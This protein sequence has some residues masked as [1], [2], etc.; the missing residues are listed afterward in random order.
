MAK[1][2]TVLITGTSSGIGRACAL[3]LAKNGYHVFA[4]VRRAE[5]G[6]SLLAESDGEIS[7]LVFDVTDDETRRKGVETIRQSVE[8]DGLDFLINN[9]GAMSAGP[10]EFLSIDNIREYLEINLIGAIALTQECLPLLRK[11]TGRIINLGSA[12]DLLTPPFFGGYTIAKWGMRGFHQALRLELRPSGIQCVLIVPGAIKT[13][14]WKDV[15][16]FRENLGLLSDGAGD[17]YGDLAI[18]MQNAAKSLSDSGLEPEV[19]AAAVERAMIA[20]RPRP[21]VIVGNDA[22]YLMRPLGALPTR[23]REQLMTRIF[24]LP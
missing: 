24:K 11:A 10:L 13:S 18:A 6:E 8:P 23:L 14:I 4:S 17:L 21:E 16:K 5:D 15:P 7:L 19:V 20:R 12:Q 9:A 2:L 3:R 1:R 22:K